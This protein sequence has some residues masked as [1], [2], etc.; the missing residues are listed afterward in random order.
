[1]GCYLGREMT[2]KEVR[3]LIV[4][5]GDCVQSAL[6]HKGL[7]GCEGKII[8]SFSSVTKP[9]VLSLLPK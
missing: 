3:Q 2:S 1:M 5:F 4:I 6:P 9:F 8:R 7:G